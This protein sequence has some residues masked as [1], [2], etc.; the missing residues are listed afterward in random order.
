MKTIFETLI[1]ITIL[2]SLCSLAMACPSSLPDHRSFLAK[3]PDSQKLNTLGLIGTHDSATYNIYILAA[4]TQLKTITEQLNGGIRVLDMRV[5][6]TNN[7]FAMHHDL[8]YLGMMFG[9]VV[10]QVRDFLRSYP[11]ELVIMFMQEECNAEGNTM[12]AC[13]ILEN[14]YIKENGDLFVQHWS[15][16]DTI[17]QDRGKILLARAHRGFWGCTTSLLCQEQNQW[18]ITSSF[19]HTDKWNAIAAFQDK[20]FEENSQSLCYINYLSAHGGIIGP[21]TIANEFS[22]DTREFQGTEGNPG[23]NNQMTKY[24]RNPKNTLYIVMA[25]NPLPQLMDKIV[26]SNF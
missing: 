2:I 15:V 23:M 16:E 9:D 10:K 4:Q 5:R 21:N 1:P 7:V 24:F 8:I 20:I 6:R 11:N 22:K 18:E 26:L 12:N 3:L 17:G 14:E 13:E 19:T 25:D